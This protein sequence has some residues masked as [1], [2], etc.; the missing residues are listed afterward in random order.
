VRGATHSN[1]IPIASACGRVCRGHGA[2]HVRL[3]FQ[4][5]IGSIALHNQWAMSNEA[6]AVT[7]PERKV[8][9]AAAVNAFASALDS[10]TQEISLRDLEPSSVSP[11]AELPRVSPARAI[12]IKVIVGAILCGCVAIMVVAGRR[13]LQR[14]HQNAATLEPSAAPAVP[15]AP[16]LATAAATAPPPASETVLAAPTSSATPAPSA[17]ALDRTPLPNKTVGIHGS[18]P[19]KPTRTIRRSAH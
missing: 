18:A 9:P 1:T 10:P 3:D 11:P 5:E 2:D 7:T 17:S 16:A 12:L 14:R 13:T 6:G 19:R 4:L 8:P 15:M